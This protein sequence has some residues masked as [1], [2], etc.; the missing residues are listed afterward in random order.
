MSNEELFR[1]YDNELILRL[2]NVKNLSDTRKML[3]R[4]KEYLGDYPP[5]AP[6]AKAYLAQYANKAPRTLYRYAQMIKAFMKW[7]G[8]A[9][10]DLKVKVPKSLPP[11]TDNSD[12]QKLFSAIEN[13]KTHKS[14]IARD[15][16]L[17][18]LD[19]KTGMRRGELEKLEARDVHADFLTVRK[20]K[21]GKDRVIPLEPVI[22]LRLQ[23][24]TKSMEPDE[25]IFKLKARSITMKIKQ[26]ARKAGLDHLHAHALR[27]KYATDLLE[28]GADIRSVQ[29]LLGH[30]NL[31]TTQIYLSITDKRLRET[32]NLLEDKP[33]VLPIDKQQLPRGREAVIEPEP[34]DETPHKRQMRELAK[35]TAEG[36]RLPSPWD[37]VLWRDLP[38]EFKP[39]KYYLPIGAVEIGEDKQIKVNYYDIGAG[40]AE[41]H[42]VKGLFSHLGTSESSKFMELVGDEG[43]LNDLVFK[44]GQY[45]QAL[46]NFLKLI[47]DEVKGYR[48]QLDFHDEGKPGLTK[49]FIIS[50]WNDAI[51]KAGGYSWIDNSWY[52][53]YESVPGTNLW[54]LRVGG[55]VIGI[56]KSKRTLKSYENWQKKLRLKYATDPLAKDIAVKDQDLGI[57]AQDV[58]QR[59]Q[60]FS[61]M[62]QVPG[63]CELC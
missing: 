39:G 19:L 25:K 31:S 29:L 51:Q 9:I 45:S 7:Y 8:E 34:Y 55:A 23:N 24:F 36:I 56:A 26:F 63:H 2:H 49:W 5:S 12:I 46:L 61:D 14:C 28:A 16:L 13:K 59:L 32:A 20:G 40:I 44:A 6:L 22:A 11:Y 42:L 53:P 15:S 54:Q 35:A 33:G 43:K 4:F 50:A 3:A 21:G 10:D 52:K 30:E 41:P 17:V 60:E 1:Q 38:V 37:K 57:I 58:K 48:V 47:T 27:H 62:Q 18:A